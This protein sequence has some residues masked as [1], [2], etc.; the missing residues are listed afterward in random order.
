MHCCVRIMLHALHCF[1]QSKRVPV[2][3]QCVGVVC[4]DANRDPHGQ[5]AGRCG[6]QQDAPLL[7]LRQQ[8]HF[9]QQVR[10]WQR[11]ASHSHQS[12]N[13][14][15]RILPCVPFSRF[16]DISVVLCF[17]CVRIA[18]FVVVVV[19]ILICHALPLPPS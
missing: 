4:P 9:G 14:R 12:H 7:S 5:R 11:T 19:I 6:G 13:L 17:L 15:V 2:E 18:G 3:Q 10:V 1:M 16:A 8:R